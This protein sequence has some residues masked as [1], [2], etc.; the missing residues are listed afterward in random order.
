M[1][2]SSEKNIICI[3]CD[4]KLDSTQREILWAVLRNNFP[5][6]E[7]TE[8]SL[9]ELNDQEYRA[10]SKHWNRVVI[11]FG[12][13]NIKRYYKNCW[14]HLIGFNGSLYGLNIE[15]KI[16]NLPRLY[17]LQSI[18]RFEIKKVALS[19]LANLSFRLFVRKSKT[20]DIK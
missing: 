13:Y 17:S 7:F 9:I 11:L 19:V 4:I 15:G 6:S 20:G 16:F 5:N 8:V 1:L 3:S 2:S 18:L 14:K 12:G 10:Q